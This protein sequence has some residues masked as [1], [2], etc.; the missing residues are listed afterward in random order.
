FKYEPY[1]EYYFEQ[2]KIIFDNYFACLTDFLWE[3]LQWHCKI[4]LPG[5]KLYR[6]SSEGISS[7]GDLIRWAKDR[8]VTMLRYYD[9]EEMYYHKNFK[10]DFQIER[11]KKPAIAENA[12]RGYKPEMAIIVALFHLGPAARQLFR[13]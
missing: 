12:G 2:L 11:L 13:K 5:K 9:D 1:F 8:G 7:M 4:L 10:H 3:L 6:S